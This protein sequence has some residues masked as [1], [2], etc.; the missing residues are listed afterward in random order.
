MGFLEIDRR[1]LFAVGIALLMSISA[2]AYA[3]YLGS[4]ARKAGATVPIIAISP[5]PTI[6]ASPSPS[7][8]AAPSPSPPMRTMAFLGDSWTLGDSFAAATAA[9][10]GMTYRADAVAGTGYA[11]GGGPTTP[12]PDP[13]SSRTTR[14]EA[15]SPDVAVIAGG[16][17]DST[18]NSTTVEKDAT[19]LLAK[20]KQD[21]SH[22][23]IVVVGPFSSSGQP[24]PT[25]LA[26]RDAI[27]N[28][29]KASGLALIDPIAE[30]WVTNANAAQYVGPDGNPTAEGHKYLASRLVADLRQLKL[31]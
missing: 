21:L 12:G 25:L 3:G 6:L 27:S 7:P 9:Q 16:Q 23:T 17:S 29:A 22:A 2:I 20:L 14:F 18:W 10:V 31:V 13:F 5:T 28:A 15:F 4:Q 1:G 8:S 30:Q 26:T 19:G 11:N 24:A